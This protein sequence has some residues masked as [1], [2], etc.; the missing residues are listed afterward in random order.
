M[1]VTSP[2]QH[3][4]LARMEVACVQKVHQQ[5]HPR[6]LALHDGGLGPKP[7]GRKMLRVVKK[8]H[9]LSVA[10]AE[11][12][13]TFCSTI[14]F[15]CPS[16]LLCFYRLRCSVHGVVMVV[17]LVIVVVVVVAAAAAAVVPSQRVEESKLRQP[18]PHQ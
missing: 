3:T 8:I 15:Y 12:A 5:V 18:L 2:L 11:V 7:Q 4:T 10:V 9:L 14:G 1:V 17:M 13:A 16:C 6:R